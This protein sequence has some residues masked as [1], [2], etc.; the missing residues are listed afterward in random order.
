MMV[1]PDDDKLTQYR[2]GTVEKAV[3]SISDSL[4]T[5]AAVVQHHAETRDMVKRMFS[6]IED[7]EDRTRNLETVVPPAVIAVQDQETRLR[8]IEREMPTLKL[9]RGWVVSG[10]VG[11]LGLVGVAVVQIVMYLPRIASSPSISQ[12]TTQIK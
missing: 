10:V 9:I 5:I 1:T 11:V 3:E 12:T 7:G 2:L 6:R 4:Q 8:V